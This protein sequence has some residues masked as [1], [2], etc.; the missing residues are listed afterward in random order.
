MNDELRAAV[1]R[2][3]SACLDVTLAGKFHA[4]FDYGAPWDWVEVGIHPS[5]EDYAEGNRP[6]HHETIHFLEAGALDKL[7]AL[8]DRLNGCLPEDAA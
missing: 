8:L 2:L 6:M 4:F 1:E 7:N 5:T 3:F